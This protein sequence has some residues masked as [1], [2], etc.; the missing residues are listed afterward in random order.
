MTNG[1]NLLN[2]SVLENLHTH[3]NRKIVFSYI[4]FKEI[5]LKI[6]LVNV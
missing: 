1:N 6:F 5:I 3:L 4:I 2:M